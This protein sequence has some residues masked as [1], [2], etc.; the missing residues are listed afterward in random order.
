ME[1]GPYWETNRHSASQ[2]ILR[3]LWNPVIHYR[4]Y[5]DL[6]LAPIMSQMNPVHIFP[7]YF[8]KI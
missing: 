5:K 3:L 6:P 4:V 8:P 1:Q 2:E 7:P